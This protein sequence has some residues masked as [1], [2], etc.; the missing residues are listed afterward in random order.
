MARK[1]FATNGTHRPLT[2]VSF[3]WVQ[4][5][6]ENLAE[7]ITPKQV[8]GALEKLPPTLEDSY[9]NLLTN[10]PQG[11][12]SLAYQALLWLAFAKRPLRLEELNEAVIVQDNQTAIDEEDRLCHS[13]LIP[14]ICRGLI[15]HHA[16]LVT[17]AH[18]SVATFLTTP[19]ILAS[20]AACFALQPDE[21]D[22]VLMHMC[23]QY[24]SMEC[25]ASGPCRTVE[26]FARRLRSYPLLL[27]AATYW[28][29]HANNFEVN[30]ID[31]DSMMKFLQT[32]R[33][34][35]GGNYCSWIQVL[36]PETAMWDVMSLQENH[37]LYYAA[38]FGLAKIVS[39]ILQNDKEIDVDTRGGR[40]GSTPLFVACWRGYYDVARILVSAGADPTVVDRG[41]RLDVLRFLHS[42]RFISPE[43]GELLRYISR[44]PNESP[45][46]N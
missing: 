46:S 35:A 15:D 26:E 3:R 11:H 14:E 32:H 34:S 9:T 41:C 27:Y 10:I 38:S 18:S 30:Q 23:L 40:F 2:E 7:Q 45:I 25:F 37:P 22:R 4:L 24:L 8:R 17:L 39:L 21:G 5:S 16:G 1:C 44:R 42:R 6:L 19:S 33:L 31:V 29:I 12:R 36:L 43:A 13:G 28:A 20:P